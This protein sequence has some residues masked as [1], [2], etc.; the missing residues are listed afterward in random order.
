MGEKLPKFGIDPPPE[1]LPEYAS[2]AKPRA[3]GHSL[4]EEGGGTLETKSIGDTSTD[5]WFL[6]H[7][8]FEIV[9][10]AVW[11]GKYLFKPGT[12]LSRICMIMFI[13]LRFFIAM[14]FISYSF[15][16]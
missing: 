2:D 12:L 14:C 6:L 4:A 9:A 10:V 8:S 5:I 16:T 7:C 11:K 13:F 3:G 1:L 15:E